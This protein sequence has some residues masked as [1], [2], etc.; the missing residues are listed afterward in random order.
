MRELLDDID[1]ARVEFHLEVLSSFDMRSELLL[2]LRRELAGAARSLQETGLQQFLDPDFPED[3]YARKLFQ[4]PGPPF[5]IDAGKVEERRLEA[6]DTLILRV[7]FFGTAGEHVVRFARLLQVVGSRGL[8]KGEGRFELDMIMARDASGNRQLIWRGGLLPAVFVLPLVNLLWSIEAL[9]P[10]PAGVK[11]IMQT[12]AR[13]LTEGKP[14]FNPG[15]ERIFPFVMRRVSSML[16]AWGGIELIRDPGKILA[17]VQELSTDCSRLQWHD[18]R[19]LQGDTGDLDLGGLL[20]EVVIDGLLPDA[21]WNLL[22]VGELLHIGKS[23]AYG[24]G[25]YRLES[26]S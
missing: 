24:A 21:V 1:L 8:F 10:D 5:V 2:H 22:R 23:A 12:P 3:P 18:W 15:F 26:R 17:A 16:Y 4:K 14:L 19:Q 25:H 13:L 11:M 7:L 9:S 6:G 20:G